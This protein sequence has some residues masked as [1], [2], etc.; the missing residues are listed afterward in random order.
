MDRFPQLRW[1]K[2]HPGKYRWVLYE[3]WPM[4]DPITQQRAVLV[5]EQNISQV[6]ALEE[7][8]KRTNE[9]LEAQLEEALAQRDPVHKPAIDIDTPADKTLKLLDKIM[10][11]QEVSARAAME[12][13]DAILQAGDLRQPVNFNEQMMKNSQTMLDSEV[14]QSLIQLLSSK[15]P[16]KVEEEPTTFTSSDSGA[17]EDMPHLRIKTQPVTQES[18]RQLIALSRNLPD[19]VLSVLAKVDDW[20]GTAG[21]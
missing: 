6:K 5:C 20:Q 21:G 10:R 8:F 15:R 17:C 13:R 11:G 16:T 18:V 7:Q 19:E 9:R 3:M 1:S 12:L 2:R 4:T 14:S